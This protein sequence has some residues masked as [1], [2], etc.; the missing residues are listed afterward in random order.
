M[1]RGVLLV[2][3]LFAAAG[4]R[5]APVSLP[6][7]PHDAAT[8]R[9]ALATVVVDNRTER[10]LDIGYHYFESGGGSVVIGRVAPTSLD[11]LPP[12]PARE[13][14]ALFAVDPDGAML[15]LGPQ[16][17]ELDTTFVWLIPASATF[18][19]PGSP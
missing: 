6:E 13:P 7:A 9:A 4:C 16:A 3:A 17:L 2:L 1:K 19:R 18:A 12:V 14:I 5:V 8:S 11:T 10:A 15:R